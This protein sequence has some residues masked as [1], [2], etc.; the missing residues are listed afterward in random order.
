MEGTN[1]KTLLIYRPDVSHIDINLKDGYQ[2]DYRLE[3]FPEASKLCTC[4]T[5]ATCSISNCP[6]LKTRHFCIPPECFISGGKCTKSIFSSIYPLYFE[7]RDTI[8]RSPYN[9]WNCFEDNPNI[10]LPYNYT[11]NIASDNLPNFKWNVIPTDKNNKKLYTV[12]RTTKD[13][14]F[15]KTDSVYI[16][17]HPIPTIKF[18]DYKRQ[19]CSDANEFITIKYAIS[20]GSPSDHIVFSYR[21]KTQK[22]VNIPSDSIVLKVED[23]KRLEISLSVTVITEYGCQN[24]DIIYPSAGD[25][26]SKYLVAGCD[27]SNISICFGQYDCD[28]ITVTDPNGAKLGNNF[29][30]TI[31]GIYTANGTYTKTNYC[32]T[33]ITKNVTAK[34]N[35]VQLPKPIIQRDEKQFCENGHITLKTKVPPGAKVE[36]YELCGFFSILISS[37]DS[38]VVNKACTYKCVFKSGNGSIGCSCETI[39]VD[40]YKPLELF[41]NH[42]ATPIIC[43]NDTI[44]LSAGKYKSYHWQPGGETTQSIVVSKPGNYWVEVDLGNNCLQFSEHTEVRTYSKPEI[45]VTNNVICS[46]KPIQMSI[47]NPEK[48]SNVKWFKNGEHISNSNETTSIEVSEP[49]QYAV[50]MMFCN[51][52][53]K[54]SQTIIEEKPTAKIIKPTGTECPYRLEA[55]DGFK[56]YKWSDGST[57]KYLDVT[58]S[59]T[60]S[61]QVMTE[62]G[63]WATATAVEVKLTAATPV[64]IIAQA[65]KV[66][67]HSSITLNAPKSGFTD[68]K[69]SNGSSEESI[70]V[71]EAGKYYLTAKNTSNCQLSTDSVTITGFTDTTK[72][73]IKSNKP[74]ICNNTVTLTAPDGYVSYLWSDGTTKKTTN[75][76]IGGKVTL[77]VKTATG[78]LLTAETVVIEKLPA[79]QLTTHDTTIC[80]GSTVQLSVSGGVTYKWEPNLGTSPSIKVSPT[81]TTIYTVTAYDNNPICF[82][83][84]V[85]TVNIAK[86]WQTT[87]SAQPQKICKGDST[88]LTVNGAKNTKWEPIPQKV[89]DEANCIVAPVKTTTYF[90]YFTNEFGCLDTSKITIEVN[91]KPSITVD[92]TNITICPQSGVVL[93]VEGGVRYVWK[94]AVNELDYTFSSVMCSP[95]VNTTYTITGFDDIGCSSTALVTIKVYP[96]MPIDIVVVNPFCPGHSDGSIRINVEAGADRSQYAIGDSSFSDNILFNNLKAGDYTLKVKDSNGCIDSSNIITLTNQLDLRANV[97]STAISCASKCDASISIYSVTGGTAPYQYQINNGKWQSKS[98]FTGLCA[99][100]YNVGIKDSKHGDDC[101]LIKQIVVSKVDTF[102]VE[103]K[104]T[105]AMC[106]ATGS[107]AIQSIRG[108]T[109]PYNYAWS[110]GSTDMELQNICSGQYSVTV[111]DNHDCSVTA[112]FTIAHNNQVST[113]KSL[114]I[115]SDHSTC[116]V[117][118]INLAYQDATNPKHGVWYGKGITAPNMGTFEYESL[119][120]DDKTSTSFTVYYEVENCESQGQKCID[121]LLITVDK[122]I[123]DT[124][125]R[126]QIMNVFTPNGDGINDT[127]FVNYA[128]NSPL[129][130]HI[131]DRWEC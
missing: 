48:V 12:T 79:I 111:T 107:I 50:Y 19:L 34:F 35:I 5:N 100:T 103:Y 53:L 113:G 20:D 130:A 122:S 73:T 68:F 33:P 81:K 98:T 1:P 54:L 15:S 127:W 52:S 92:K 65:L 31:S 17:L 116:L 28:G 11:W 56:T 21:D 105:D 60:Y 104:A 26:I 43:A 8:I 124:T 59:G 86:T 55:P 87:T 40:R 32:N 3:V 45:K 106:S 126:V 61:L 38:V 24:S 91:I 80:S 110:N 10:D 70:D 51:D 78:C 23:L 99:G 18:N 75:I 29:N 9:Y 76:D 118:S 108:G 37:A 121:S 102:T 109:P 72:I 44:I 74:F 84:D 57:L 14:C 22:V 112:A 97:T 115:F 101:V 123:C 96:T 46:G 69:W 25:D 16:V 47:G 36:W 63:C 49:G 39:I 88:V 82:S 71:T 64:K 27:C 94:P 2:K 114:T 117:P 42:G 62:N 129:E 4:P 120:K 13:K 128:G 67:N 131:Y 119:S 90:A 66:C 83:S 85:V 41:S 93:N 58:K 30:P 89:I 6:A 125:N 95:S 7:K 77:Q